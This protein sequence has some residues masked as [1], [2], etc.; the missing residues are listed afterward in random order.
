MQNAQVNAK[1][2][3][4]R[5]FKEIMTETFNCKLNNGKNNEGVSLFK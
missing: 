5:N 1:Y 3:N 2:L 4:P